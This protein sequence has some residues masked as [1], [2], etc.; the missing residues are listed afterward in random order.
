ME[1]EGG[2][3]INVEARETNFIEFEIE[4]LLEISRQGHIR[5]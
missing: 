3:F 2:R 5:L 4:F 1:D